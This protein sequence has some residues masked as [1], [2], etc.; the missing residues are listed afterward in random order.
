ML[1]E[2]WYKFNVDK[3]QRVFNV[4]KYPFLIDVVIKNNIIHGEFDQMKTM[5]TSNHLRKYNSLIQ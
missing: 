4:W 1:K 2:E 3:D 5:Q